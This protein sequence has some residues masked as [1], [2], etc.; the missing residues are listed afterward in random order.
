MKLEL[1][2]HSPSVEY[3]GGRQR[4]IALRADTSKLVVHTETIEAGKPSRYDDGD[5][6]GWGDYNNDPKEAQWKAWERFEERTRRLLGMDA[7]PSKRLKEAGDIAQQII[8]E[9]LPD[10][11]ESR[12]EQVE[13]DYM[14]KSN[15]DS[16]EAFTGHKLY[17]PREDE[18]DADDQD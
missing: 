5:Y 6:F 10:D 13:E 1:I 14:L 15:L 12:T 16:F 7:P 2:A 3:D 4:R 17:E 8:D 9:L 11:P 18:D